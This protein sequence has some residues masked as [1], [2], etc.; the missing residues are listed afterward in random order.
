MEW[1]TLPLKRYAQFTGRARRK[2]YWSFFLLILAAYI[3]AGIVDGILGMSTLVGGVYGPL[4]LLTALFFFI[5][6]LAV[7]VRRLHDTNRSGWWILI[8]FI[9]LIGALVLIYFFILEGTRGP[10][11][12][13]PDPKEGEHATP[14]AV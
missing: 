5:P 10:N 3:V 2:E 13:G 7:G 14:S 11:Q 12:Y 1:A 8:G 9:P 6:S 4:T